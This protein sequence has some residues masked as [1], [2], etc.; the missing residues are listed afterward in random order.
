MTC[1]VPLNGYWFHS[2]DCFRARCR[3]D[4]YFDDVWTSGSNAGR[5]FCNRSQIF[6]SL[7]G[8]SVG[9]YGGGAAPIVATAIL[10]STGETIGISIYIALASLVTW[11][12]IFLLKETNT[13][14]L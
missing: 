13:R 3:S 2:V 6:W 11:V 12:S 8:L 14:S 9:S 4:H 10:A 5:T 1:G 7:F